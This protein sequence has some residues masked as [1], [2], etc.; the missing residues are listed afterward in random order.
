MMAVSPH[1]IL[2]V[3]DESMLKELKRSDPSFEEWLAAH[4][5]RDPVHEWERI[6]QK[7]QA[8][9]RPTPAELAFI[10]EYRAKL[11]EY[12]RCERGEKG[13]AQRVAIAEF[14]E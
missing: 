14:F 12:S 10:G 4:C 2:I 8:G 9:Q 3:T 1:Q 11:D 6:G 13:R 5:G 7:A